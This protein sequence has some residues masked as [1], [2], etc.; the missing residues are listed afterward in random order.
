VAR[1]MTHFELSAHP[2]YMD[3]YTSALFL[4]HT[5]LELFPSVKS[6]LEGGGGP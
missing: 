4:P 1:M 2:G 6:N 3:Y 5:N